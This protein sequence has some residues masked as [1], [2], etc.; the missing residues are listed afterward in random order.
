MGCCV[1]A[2]KLVASASD[3]NRIRLWDLST[4]A[5]IFT[6]WTPEDFLRLSFSPN[7]SYLEADEEFL[8]YAPASFNMSSPHQ[9]AKVHISLQGRWIVGTM[10][11][12]LWLPPDYQASCS[13]LRD[14]TV[15]LGHASGAIS[16]IHFD[17][18][19]L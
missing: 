12:L 15:V 14:T 5:V 9:P 7:G 10:G 17:L 1:L 13:A 19:Q 18:S 11:N 2:G 6:C 3:A 8:V 4:G 16:F